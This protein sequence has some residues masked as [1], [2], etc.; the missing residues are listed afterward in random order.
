MEIATEPLTFLQLIS[1]IL[2][3]I[4]GISGILAFLSKKGFTLK[5][6]DSSV[7]FGGNKKEELKTNKMSILIEACTTKDDINKIDNI[8]YNRQRKLCKEKV[9]YLISFSLEKFREL[10][11]KK[12]ELSFPQIISNL[13]YLYFYL[14]MNKIQTLTMNI[15]MNDFEENGLHNKQHENTYAYD[16]AKNCLNTLEDEID[17]LYAGVENVDKE[18]FEN[19]WTT[20]I[21][22]EFEKV[23]IDIYN[24]AVEISV[25]GFDR[26]IELKKHLHE[27]I[28]EIE[29]MS[30]AQFEKM[31]NKNGTDNFNI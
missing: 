13:D 1:V 24:K 18:D 6:K 16:R 20:E 8:V 25:K 10:A 29:I 26:K 31:F 11:Q 19:L 30:T 27:K 3:I 2:I 14:L 9:S 5:R 23:I 15:L 4:A 7:I 22:P 28:N 12:L 17:Y 21:K